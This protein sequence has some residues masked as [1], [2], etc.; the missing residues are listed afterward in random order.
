MQALVDAAF[1]ANQL[2]RTDQTTALAIIEQECVDL[3][4]EHFDLPD[5]DSV[6]RLYELLRDEI[7]PD[8]VPTTAGI[9]TAH[10]VGMKLSPDLAAYNPLLMWELSFARAAGRSRAER[11]RA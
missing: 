3:L 5:R 11:R 4:T 1:D 2:F 6:V 7:A 8:P 9:L 10:R